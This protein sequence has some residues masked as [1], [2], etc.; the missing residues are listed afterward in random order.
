M[1]YGATVRWI[2]CIGVPDS[3]Q[4]SHNLRK[5]TELKIESSGTFF[6]AY[7]THVYAIWQNLTSCDRVNICINGIFCR[8]STPVPRQTYSRRERGSLSL[9]RRNSA[10]KHLFP[11]CPLYPCHPIPHFLQTPSQCAHAHL[12]LTVT[13]QSHTLPSGPSAPTSASFSTNS[14]TAT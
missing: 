7:K 2:S 3:S 10:S 1:F 12:S 8:N 6:Q 11:S 14:T 5:Q 4:P 9:I 13:T